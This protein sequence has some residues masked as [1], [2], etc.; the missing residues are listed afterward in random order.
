MQAKPVRG[1]GRTPSYDEAVEIWLRLLN[2]DYQHKIAADFGF[3]QGRISEVKKRT[4]HPE[5]FDA[6]MTKIVKH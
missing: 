1:E 5:A 4:R 2:G 6:A 3:N